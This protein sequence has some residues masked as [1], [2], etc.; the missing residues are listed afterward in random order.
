MNG[1]INHMATSC[2]VWS[3]L[4]VS[5]H[6]WRELKLGQSKRERSRHNGFINEAKKSSVLLGVF[7]ACNFPYEEPLQ[8]ETLLGSSEFQSS[9]PF[10]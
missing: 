6:M 10:Q 7:S 3:C 4:V 2:L 9:Q 1:K 5:V 8:F